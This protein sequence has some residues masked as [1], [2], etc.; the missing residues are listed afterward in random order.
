LEGANVPSV[1]N[2]Y[3]NFGDNARQALEFYKGVFGGDLLLNTFGEYGDP[4]APGADNI[5][6]GQLE[7]DNGMTLMAADTP[8]GMES[9][10][11]GGNITI[12]LSG[13]DEQQLR[14]Y[15]DKLAEGGNVTMPLEKQMWGDVFGMCTDQYGVPWMVDIVPPPS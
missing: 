4:N 11:G 9:N 2:P 15:W 13:D 10:A 6:H 5:M 3:I 7:T 14:G 8:P 12:S 1:L